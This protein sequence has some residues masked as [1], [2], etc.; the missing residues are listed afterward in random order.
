MT[1]AEPVLDVPAISYTEIEQQQRERA[2]AVN[3]AP[4]SRP[5]QRLKTATKRT[6][7]SAPAQAPQVKRG[8]VGPA[9]VA[10]VEAKIADGLNAS[11]AFVVVAGERRTK[12]G[13]VSANYYRVKRNNSAKTRSP[14]KRSAVRKVVGDVTPTC[15]SA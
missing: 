3:A 12:A 10:A 11:Q 5:S 14:E 6:A 13:A 2:E 9:V 4:K 1:E 8:E 15:D 7:R